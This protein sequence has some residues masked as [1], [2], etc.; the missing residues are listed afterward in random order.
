M[1]IKKRYRFGLMFIVT[2]AFISTSLL[3]ALPSLGAEE[4]P[5]W[6]WSRR[7]PSPPKWWSWG[8]DYEPGEPARGGYV[9][10]AASR[11]IGLMN[12]NHW[13]VNDWNNMTYMFEICMY[14]D[15]NFK[16]SVPWLAKDWEFTDPLTL[17][18]ELRKGIQFH[19]GTSFNAESFKYQVDWIK[20]K[21]NGAWSRAYLA[22]VDS[23]E[24]VGPHSLK[25]NLKK[26]WPGIFGN[27]AY[28]PGYAISMDALKQDGLFHDSRKAVSKA[29]KARKKADKTKKEKD[30]K[31]AEKLE[32][33]AKI[34]VEKA[35][36]AKNSD[37]NPV[38]TGK[39]MLEEGKPGNY[40][41]LKRN[42]NWWFA[43]AIGLPLP[44]PDGIIT[45]VIPDPSIQLANLR[46]GKI[47]SM[48][49]SP[50]QYDQLKDD[51]KLNVQISTW[52]H[53][54]GL[55]FNHIE[56]PCKDIR[57]RKAISHAIDRKALIFGTMFGLADEASGP[58]PAKH[59]AHNPNL[60]PVSYDPELSKKLLVEAGYPKGLTVKGYYSN[61]STAV[62]IAEAVK[63]ML[64]NVGIKWDVEFL[65]S[66]ASSDRNTNLEYEFAG[67]GWGFIWDPD[68]MITGLYHPDGLS[69]K[70][71]FVNDKIIA[72]IETG[73]VEMDE[74]K[75]QK[76]YWDI[77]KE[78]YDIYAD[79][80][81]WYPKS[82][83]VSS[84][85]LLGS[86]E[87][88]NNLGLEGFYHSHPVWLKDGKE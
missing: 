70:G 7:M 64:Q 79:V 83:T 76:I 5:K 73:R 38:G 16:P 51:P 37:V 3:S 23:V 53:S 59:W 14:N 81:L 36:G 87:E 12:P 60:K 19:D 26:P 27:I 80:W 29:E 6:E 55:K 17:V 1:K 22:L 58:Y 10:L 56:G 72:M 71:R 11:Y 24:A 32:A 44:Y 66:A 9:R 49:V 50:A 47:H 4:T 48:G 68:L 39:Y 82:V 20:D 54:T 33:Q 42:P 52:P 67:G 34:L 88:F 18:M 84:K 62:N 86:N 61:S 85:K 77:E 13:P 45:M 63:A 8:K 25:W 69:N 43:K 65:D 40:L 35:K 21:K 30:I 74:K 15:G 28:P 46:A 31:K 41:K 2:A 78:L 75:R 57:V